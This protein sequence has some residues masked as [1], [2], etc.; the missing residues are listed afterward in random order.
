MTIKNR[1]PFENELCDALAKMRR[2]NKILCAQFTHAVNALETI[3]DMPADLY[4]MEDVRA[5][6]EYGLKYERAVT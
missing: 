5:V 2:E 6:V 4:D 3:A 1:T